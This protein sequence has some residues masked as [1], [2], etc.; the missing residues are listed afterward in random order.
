MADTRGRTSIK[1][2]DS[3]MS[4]IKREA[5]TQNRSVHN[6]ILTILLEH[7]KNKSDESKPD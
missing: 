1:I 4:E 5:D 2:P 6:M 7:Y 3:L